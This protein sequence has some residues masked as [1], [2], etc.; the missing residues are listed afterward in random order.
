MSTSILVNY[1]LAKLAVNTVSLQGVR[2]AQDVSPVQLK[3]IYQAGK[4][5]TRIAERADLFSISSTRSV[6]TVQLRLPA[7]CDSIRARVS[8]LY[9]VG[10]CADAQVHYLCFYILRDLPPESHTAAAVYRSA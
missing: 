8:A 3:H 1:H 2:V 9:V 6:S 5:Q 7:T 10:L 4:S